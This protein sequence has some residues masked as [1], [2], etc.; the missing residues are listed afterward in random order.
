MSAA[1]TKTALQQLLDEEFAWRF[2]E[3]Q[4]HRTVLRS[5]DG[6]RKRMLLRTGIALLYAHWEGFVKN[7]T[8]FYIEFVHHQRLNYQ[9]LATC[10]AV[11]GLKSELELLQASKKAATNIA[12]LTAI[13][14]ATNRVAQI[15]NFEVQTASN[16]KFDIFEGVATTIGISTSTYETKRHFIDDLVYQRNAVAHGD[17]I[18]IDTQ[19]YILKSDEVIQLMRN[20]KTDI[21]NSFSQNKF[22][23]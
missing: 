16:L 11:L 14:S 17:K 8:G 18:T 2:R 6:P 22:R 21:E 12:A 10:F 23:L 9:E 20:Y 4:D 7:C 5:A 1:R 13:R 19:D 3:L 15:D